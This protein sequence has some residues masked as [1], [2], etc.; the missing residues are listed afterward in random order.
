MNWDTNVKELNDTWINFQRQIWAYWMGST[1]GNLGEQPWSQYY[2]QSMELSENWVNLMVD[3]QSSMTQ[4]FLKSLDPGDNAPL[5]LTQ[6]CAQVQTVADNW[7]QALRKISN[8]WFTAIRD[9]ERMHKAGELPEDCNIFKAWQDAT[10]KTLAI[11]SNWAEQ[12]AQYNVHA[13]MPV[14][15][16]DKVPAAAEKSASTPSD[17]PSTH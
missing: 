12:L 8:V 3:N 13:G 17:T 9:L 2:Q 14:M 4:A 6:Y 11:Q 10:E 16:R 15:C 7:N 5:M 1:A